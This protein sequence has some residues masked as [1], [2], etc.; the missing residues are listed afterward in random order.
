M[1]FT[2]NNTLDSEH[3]VR[4]E[5]DGKVGYAYCVAK[6]G[7]DGFVWLY[8]VAEP[9]ASLEEQ[10]GKAAPLNP[11]TYVR[12]VIFHPPQSE[13]DIGFNWVFREGVWECGIYIRSKLHAIVGKGDRPGWCVLAAEDGPLACT[14]PWAE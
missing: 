6:D 3:A 13:T 14:L 10:G 7:V 1:P 12:D 9:P 5:D 11:P 4:V 2:L 8:N